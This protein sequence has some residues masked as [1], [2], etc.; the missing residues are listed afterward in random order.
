MVNHHQWATI[1]DFC[2]IVLGGGLLPGCFNMN[3]T[4]IDWVVDMDYLMRPPV[5]EHPLVPVS[6]HL[7]LSEY[8]LMKQFICRL[9]CAL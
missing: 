9:M 2:G 3:H 8:F 6:F 4:M 5:I 7:N 1:F